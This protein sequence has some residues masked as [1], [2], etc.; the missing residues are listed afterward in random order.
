MRI[1]G[2]SGAKLACLVL[3]GLLAACSPKRM[4]VDM[5]GSAMAGSGGAYA[6]DDDPELVR[7]ALPFGLKTME[8]LLEVSKTSCAARGRCGTVPTGST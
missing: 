6:T 8:G 3:A 7:E 2:H 1:S 4:M 5:V